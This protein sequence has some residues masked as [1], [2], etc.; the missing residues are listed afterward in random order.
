[1]KNTFFYREFYRRNLPHYQPED[2]IFFITT[3]LAFSLPEYI[4]KELQ[5]KK[6]LFEKAIKYI[7]D[8]NK[9]ELIKEFHKSYF[10]KF[11]EFL[12]KFNKSPKWLY[13]TE[14]AKIVEDN[15]NYWNEKRYLLLSYCIMPNHL[16]LMIKPLKTENNI[17]ESL[18]KI[19]FG[20]KSYTAN[21]C[22][23][24]LER[25]GQFW[26]NESAEH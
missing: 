16:H 20:M 17:Y 8:Q 1:M 14:I 21:E 26:H 18:K 24:I 22:N 23:K 6:E 5:T 4:L 12:D 11:D 9:K 3:R 13:K 10:I 19:M 2:G 15:L 7:D 25:T